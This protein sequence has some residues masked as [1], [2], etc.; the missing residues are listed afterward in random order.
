MFVTHVVSGLAMAMG[1]EDYRRCALFAMV[2]LSR[3]IPHAACNAVISVIA[4][5]DRSVWRPDSGN[6]GLSASPCICFPLDPAVFGLGLS[7]SISV[8]LEPPN[9]P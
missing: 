6:T 1:R 5:G 4:L 8:F 3:L 9:R 7:L 2:R